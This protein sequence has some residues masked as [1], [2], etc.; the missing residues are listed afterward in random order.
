MA[1]TEQMVTHE[2]VKITDG[3]RDQTVQFSGDIL[4]CNSQTQPVPDSPAL[5]F[6]TT[7]RQTLTFTKDDTVWAR[8]A[9]SEGVVVLVL[10]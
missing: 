7:A 10:W 5:R 1:T 6:E 9:S 8:A 4:F 2:W 3:T